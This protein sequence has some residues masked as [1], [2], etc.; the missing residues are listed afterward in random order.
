VRTLTFGTL[1]APNLRPLYQA[2]VEHLSRSTGVEIALARRV[3]YDDFFEGGLDGGFL[4]GLPYVMATG[5]LALL[6]APVLKRER[7]LDRPVY[8]SDVIVH[9][10]SPFERFEDLRGTTWAF[11]EPLSHSGYGVVRHHLVSLGET[12]GFFGKVME[13]GF[14]RRSIRAVADRQVD[15]SAIDSQVLDLEILG[16]P[17]LSERLRVIAS[18]GPSTIQPVVVSSRI[19]ASLAEDMRRALAEMHLEDG[20]RRVLAEGLMERFQAIDD[21]DYDGI[22]GMLRA[23]EDAG[24]MKIF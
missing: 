23:S 14:H 3:S 24:F 7:Y 18:L 9:R 8:Y 22:R 20:Y 16:D 4:C 11:N 17:S 5:V 1:L 6:G 13:T 19:H 2:V 15:A 10:D 12:G 21:G